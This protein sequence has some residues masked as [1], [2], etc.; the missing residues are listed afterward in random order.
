MYI[1]VE[2]QDRCKYQNSNIHNHPH[3][4]QYKNLNLSHN[5]TQYPTEH[6]KSITMVAVA[7]VVVGGYFLVKHVKDRREKKK[8]RKQ[9]E[10]GAVE[11]DD[12]YD[13]KTIA[14][15]EY[16]FDYSDAASKASSIYSRDQHAL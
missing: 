8:V 2:E 3:L 1:I 13:D 12:Q 14:P 10:H 15:P 16:S 6:Y 7:L 5:Q 9:Q 4:S 11:Y